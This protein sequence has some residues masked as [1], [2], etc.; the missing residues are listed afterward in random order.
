MG[1]VQNIGRLPVIMRG[2]RMEFLIQLILVLLA[3]GQAASGGVAEKTPLEI[4][5]YRVDRIPWY[6]SVRNQVEQLMF[7]SRNWWPLIYDGRTLDELNESEFRPGH[8]TVLVDTEKNG[9]ILLICHSGTVDQTPSQCEEFR[10]YLEPRNSFWKEYIPSEDEQSQMEEIRRERMTSTLGWSMR[11]LEGNAPEQS[12]EVV[13]ISY[14][15]HDIV[16]DFRAD[17]KSVMDFLADPE[18]ALDS[19]PWE[20]AKTSPDTYVILV[21]CGWGPFTPATESQWG[22]WSRYGVLLKPK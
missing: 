16:E 12:F 8:G 22:T 3:I 2:R 7:D 20:E 4:D 19:A 17:T 1:A 18:Y 13:G 6:Y 15:P 10:R 11:I 21:F 5:L 9:N 14:I